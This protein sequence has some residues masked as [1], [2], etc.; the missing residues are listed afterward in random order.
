MNR[1]V[2][3]TAHGQH[4][5]P[6]DSICGS[7]HYLIIMI[8]LVYISKGTRL[9]SIFRLV[10]AVRDIIFWLISSLPKK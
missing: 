8:N 9:A 10:I 5:D 2:K 1:Y 4:A 6:E 7:Q 3:L